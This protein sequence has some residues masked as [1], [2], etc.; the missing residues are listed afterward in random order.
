MTS[1]SRAKVSLPEGD[2]RALLDIVTRTLSAGTP[3]SLAALLR[4]RLLP[5]LGAETCFH[6]WIDLDLL[7]P[8]IIGA[9][10]I[11]QPE[12]GAIQA[13]LPWCPLTRHLIDRKRLVAAYDLDVPRSE[14]HD[15][16]ERFF[17]AHPAG[18]GRGRSYLDD[19]RTVLLT[20]DRSDPPLVIGFHR[21]DASRESFTRR[22]VRIL[23]IL[24]PHLC[25]AIRTLASREGSHGRLPVTDEASLPSRN[26]TVQVTGGS[27][28]VDQNP[29]FR[30]LF[31]CRPG[32]SLSSSLTRVLAHGI[33]TH[34]RS[35][36]PASAREEASW[37]CL[38]PSLFQVDV[39]RRG[40]D[41]WLLELHLST[42]ACPGCNPIL[43]EFGLTAKEKEICC[44]VR[45]GFD[46]REIA[47]QL[48]MSIHTAK[49]HLKNIYRKLDIPNRARL[50]SFLNTT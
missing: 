21:L 26:P 40:D 9:V 44:R 35:S 48:C 19:L 2:Y 10:G 15:S 31:D 20:L 29:A 18:K 30:K 8:R 33:E 14:L 11:P 1:R 45:Q 43:R 4:S 16:V 47:S 50:V 34:G 38:C 46:N 25:R 3:R 27:K 13:F 12:I 28:I 7:R 39:S 37:F 22:E 24:R 32:D 36:A 23:E 17:G 41:L 49:T 5:L 6:A 42:G